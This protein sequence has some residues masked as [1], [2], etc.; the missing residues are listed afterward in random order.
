M[1]NWRFKD[2]LLLAA[3]AGTTL[4]GNHAVY[5]SDVEI[6]I[7][8]E[9]EKDEVER[10]FSGA[11]AEIFYGQHVTLNFKTPLAVSGAAGNAPAIAPLLLACGLV[12]V[13]T[14]ESVTYT[15]G[16]ATGAKFLLRFGDNT[17]AID[18]A[19]GNV[20]FSLEKGK[21]MLNW[22]FKGLFS[23]PTQS[24][25]TPTVDWSRWTQ[26]KTLGTSNNSTFTLNNKTRTLHKLNVDL[27]NN[28]IFDRAINHEE[29]IISGHESSANI[30]ITASQ[31]S[32]FD[33]FDAIGSVQDFVFSHGS[34]AGQRVS[35]IGRFQMPIPK[36]TSLESEQTGYELDGKLLPS[37]S[38]LDEF[39]LVFE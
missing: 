6:A 15:R 30:T 9:T 12:Q 29:I 22:Q 14:A 23:P 32:D 17:H 16:D 28:V 35:V 39:N 24:D 3:A 27:G 11:T 1:S 25:E 34:G 31:L 2:K 4:T 7:E 21:P 38:G 10:S 37:G 19:K 18:G 13:S 33:P 8:S 26:P 20:S 36:Y 5:A